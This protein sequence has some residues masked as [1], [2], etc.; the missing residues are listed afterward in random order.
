MVTLELFIPLFCKLNF[1]EGNFLYTFIRALDRNDL[2]KK[3]V[4]YLNSFPLAPSVVEKINALEDQLKAFPGKEEFLSI[5][6]EINGWID[7]GNRL[8][9]IKTSGDGDVE[10][11]E[12]KSE[13]IIN[14]FY[15][16]EVSEI[17]DKFNDG[18]R[19]FIESTMFSGLSRTKKIDELRNQLDELND[20][21]LRL[22]RQKIGC[23]ETWLMI[24]DALQVKILDL[25][26]RLNGLNVQAFP[27]YDY[28]KLKE[29]I[30]NPFEPKPKE[31][32][33]LFQGVQNNWK[34]EEYYLFNAPVEN[35]SDDES[36]NPE[37]TQSND[38]NQRI[39]QDDP[40]G[41]EKIVEMLVA[42]GTLHEK[43]RSALIDYLEERIDE[44]V[45]AGSVHWLGTADSFTQ[46]IFALVRTG[47]YRQQGSIPWRN[48]H[49]AL[50]FPGGKT[51]QVD[52]LKKLYQNAKK[53]PDSNLYIDIVSQA[54]SSALD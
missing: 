48:W 14:E 52:T 20:I 50:R 9:S 41:I 5:E 18:F 31:G 8:E 49:I 3:A 32:P 24:I 36:F 4:S 7:G 44:D 39:S 17:L 43:S 34:G 46:F 53:N 45:A 6:N 33:A 35:N 38:G 30:H 21:I 28:E 25:V 47:Q 51:I 15:Y 23:G 19:A 11:V 22:S 37:S 54:L 26:E 12:V 1:M 16:R 40:A 10:L 29:Y 13:K 2:H 42:N 27:K